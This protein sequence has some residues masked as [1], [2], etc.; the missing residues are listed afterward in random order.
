MYLNLSN[1]A[2]KVEHSVGAKGSDVYTTSGSALVDLSVRLV[3]GG[4]NEEMAALF[5]K[6]LEGAEDDAFVLAFQTRDVRGGK[7]E[8][9]LFYQMLEELLQRR[10]RLMK[11][12]LDLIPEYGCWR[13]L[14]TEELRDCRPEIEDLVIQQLKK[15]AAANPE[16]S[17]SLC[18]KWA[19]REGKN[20][21]A[22]KALAAKLFPPEIPLSQRLKGYRQLVAGL[23]RRLDTTEIKM[24][25]AKWA[26]IEPAAVP[27]VCLA[28]NMKAFLNQP[29]KGH[30]LRRPDD[31]DR[32]TCR[33]HFQEHMA[34]AAKGEAKVNGAVTRYPHQ[35]IK[36]VLRGAEGAERESLIAVW[37]GMVANAKALGGLGRTIAM[38]D[39]SGSMQSAGTAKDTPYWVSMA[40]GL[41]ISEVTS[42]EFKDMFL[43]FDSNPSWHKLPAAAD[44]F[45]RVNSIGHIG[46]GLSTDFQKAMDLVLATLKEKRVRPGQEPKDL[47]VITDMAWDQACASNER[48]GYTGHSY[49]HVVKTSPWQTHIQ[50]IRE[51]FR[52]AGE[53]MWGVP[54]TPPRIVIWNVA[55]T[56][57]DFHATAD[58]EGVIMLG[59]WSPSLFKVLT[60]EGAR[61]Q[62]PVEA[63]RVQLDDERYAAI[64]QRLAELRG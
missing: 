40:M 26:Q 58:T 52:R 50:M 21:P 9:K 63:L 8:R 25:G 12:L 2:T 48:S 35:V 17:I 32:N 31:A 11:G 18:A 56:C 23:N 45:S 39:F 38:C 43:T 1:M 53:D 27:G 24:C 36:D 6:A 54:W 14:Y 4:W 44:I 57:N 34:K 33:E 20:T 62:T 10:P 28:K 3:R 7:G 30:G 60:E 47:I 29:L 13:D 37:N 49:R 19:P 61:V 5:L 42:D 22:A 59:G 64:R 55:A 15:D 16:A 41:L 46:Q 51:S